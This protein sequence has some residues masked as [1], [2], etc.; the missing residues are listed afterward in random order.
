MMKVEGFY[1]LFFD[2]TRQEKAKQEIERLNRELE[3]RVRERT[4]DLG[5]ANREL[6]SFQIAQH[7]SPILQ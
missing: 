4:A 2:I 3:Q 7:C 1:G 5:A 6:E